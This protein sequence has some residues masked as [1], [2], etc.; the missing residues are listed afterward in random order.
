M[1]RW[2]DTETPR[3]KKKKNIYKHGAV[4]YFLG[5]DLGRGDWFWS[6]NI[7]QK[8]QKLFIFSLLFTTSCHQTPSSLRSTFV[9]KSSCQQSRKQGSLF[10]KL[11]AVTHHESRFHWY[12]WILC[13]ASYILATISTSASI[14]SLNQSNLPWQP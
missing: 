4:M 9:K 3:K 8:K 11:T 5:T 10:P 14:S 12:Q 7:T 1:F 2:S 13:I 6:I